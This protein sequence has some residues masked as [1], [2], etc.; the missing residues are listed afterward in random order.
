MGQRFLIVL[1]GPMANFLLAILIIAAFFATVGMPRTPNLV[2]RV[3]PGSAAEK[4]GI[5]P[6]DRIESIDG[7]DTAHVRE[8]CAMSPRFV[9]ERNVPIHVVRGSTVAVR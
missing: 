1:A 5:R 4:A 7:Q 8:F 9:P 6:G 2:E 3:V